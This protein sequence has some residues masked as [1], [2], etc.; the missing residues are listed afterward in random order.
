MGRE[1]DGGALV[2]VEAEVPLQ[3]IVLTRDRISPLRAFPTCGSYKA[4][5]V[6]GVP[7]RRLTQSSGRSRIGTGRTLPTQASLSTPGPCTSAVTPRSAVAP[8]IAAASSAPSMSVPF[9]AGCDSGE[10]LRLFFEVIGCER[11]GCC[12]KSR[13]DGV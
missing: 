2:L 5:L 4:S 3:T 12:R 11:L 9:A 1:T 6:M 8:W 13:F 7:V 10:A